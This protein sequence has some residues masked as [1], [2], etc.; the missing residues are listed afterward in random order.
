MQL[1]SKYINPSVSHLIHKF[2]RTLR[3]QHNHC[4]PGLLYVFG[5]LAASLLIFAYMD[6]VDIVADISA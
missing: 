2:P 1:W 4:F 6:N 5:G 3:H